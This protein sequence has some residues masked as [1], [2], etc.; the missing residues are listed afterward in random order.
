MSVLK[1]KEY[2]RISAM[3]KRAYPKYRKH[4]VIL[5]DH[6]ALTNRGSYWD[7]GS[8]SFYDTC[9]RDGSNCKRVRGPANPPQFGGGEPVRIELDDDTI[10]L[11]CG[12]FRG[13]PATVCIY[14]TPATA[15]WLQGS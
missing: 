13:K 4:S 8:R 12:T 2:P 10:G 7:G 9:R 5:F 15:E 14:A 6:G 11:Q 3:I 1:I